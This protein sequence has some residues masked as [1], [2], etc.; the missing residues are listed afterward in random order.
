MW[1][2]KKNTNLKVIN[3]KEENKSCRT[4]KEQSLNLGTKIEHL[5]R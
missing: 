4:E 3:K 2:I 5:Y 1:L